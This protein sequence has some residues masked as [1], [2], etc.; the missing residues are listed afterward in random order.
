MT[1]HLRQQQESRRRETR[2][3]YEEDSGVRHQNHLF[4]P[5]FYETP[6]SRFSLNT[7]LYP[8]SFVITFYLKDGAHF[9]SQVK[10]FIAVSE[11]ELSAEHLSAMIQSLQDT[12]QLRH[13]PN[14]LNTANSLFKSITGTFSKDLTT[15]HERIFNIQSIQYYDVDTEDAFKQKHF[16]RQS[17]APA[18]NLSNPLE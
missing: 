11:N 3:Y 4:A 10:T 5:D 7:N 15:V 1:N 9:Y 14:A 8:V 18:P 12:H 2:R 13:I 6:R 17:F 16:P